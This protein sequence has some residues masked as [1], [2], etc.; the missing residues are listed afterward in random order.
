MREI[1]G[2]TSLLE[3]KKKTAGEL[4][5]LIGAEEARRAERDP[6]ARRKPRHCGITIHTGVGCSYGCVYCYIWDMGFP[7]TPRRYQLTP[8]QM[9]YALAVNPYVL[10]NST[11]AAYGSV[12]EPFLPETRDDALEYIRVVYE[13]L[14]LPSQVSTKSILDDEIISGLKKAEPNISVLVTVVALGR[15]A[16]RLEANAPRAEDRLEAAVEAGRRGL[17]VAVFMR[18]IIP[19]VA[20]RHYTSIINM[21]VE[22]GLK[23]IVLGSLRATKG[24][25]SRLEAVG[26]DSSLLEARI[27][28]EQVYVK[29]QVPVDVRDLKSRIAAYALKKGMVVHPSACSHNMW[30][31]RQS[32]HACKYGPCYSRPGLPD[33]E[34]IVEAVEALGGR[35][36]SVVVR[37]PYIILHGVKGVR[38]GVL[39]E[40]LK[41]ATRLM[42][43]V[44]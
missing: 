27:P 39:T 35:V 31:H 20:E 19:G 15:D 2:I 24:I 23:H 26:I 10:P 42:V 33:E 14:G 1:R 12:M 22:G 18:P 16:R 3:D 7:G 13:W 43:R 37:Y 28:G 40:L 17:N 8:L 32:C 25:I 29:R 44:A 36:R 41:A 9:A 30:S 21:A 6:H 34:D 11:M 4:R 38:R 5:E